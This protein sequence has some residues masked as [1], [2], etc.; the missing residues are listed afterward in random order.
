MES[1]GEVVAIAN[2]YSNGP[3]VRGEGAAGS[4]K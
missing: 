2:G 3:D 4:V 1:R